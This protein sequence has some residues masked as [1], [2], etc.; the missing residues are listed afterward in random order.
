MTVFISW[1]GSFSKAVA[2]L[3]NSWLPDVI[4]GVKTWLSSEDIDKGSIWSDELNEA[5]STTVGV[6]CVTQEN[7]DAR[8]LLFETG[9]L[10]KGLTKARVCPLLIDLQ[11]KDLQPPLSHFNLTLPER[12]E[13]WQLVKAIN[14]TDPEN[15]LDE[16]RLERSFNKW[17]EVFDDGLKTIR[18]KQKTAVKAPE[19]SEKEL[20]VEILELT[21]STQRA[22]ER[23]ESKEKPERLVSDFSGWTDVPPAREIYKLR[24]PANWQTFKVGEPERA[25][26]N[27]TKNLAEKKAKTEGEEK[28]DAPKPPK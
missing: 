27:K 10:S 6:V 22:V 8:W 4:Q 7:K 5:L 24:M 18:E 11:S 20:I 12:G 14:S 3:L 9:A 25:S 13:M 16:K 2:E 1:S 15:A 17:W 23:I 19:R 26:E 28:S 21:R